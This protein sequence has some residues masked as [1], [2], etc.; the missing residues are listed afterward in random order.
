[1]A[2]PVAERRGRP[3]AVGKLHGAQ[4]VDGFLLVVCARE[5]VE[6]ARR[7]QG[8]R[9]VVQILGRMRFQV[10]ANAVEALLGHIRG[11]V[12]FRGDAGPGSAGRAYRYVRFEW[13]EKQPWLLVQCN[14]AES[15]KWAAF[16]SENFPASGSSLRFSVGGLKFFRLTGSSASAGTAATRTE[17]AA[18]D[19]NRRKRFTGPIS[20][21]DLGVL[22]HGDC[23]KRP[24]PTSPEE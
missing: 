6:I 23:S 16:S 10:G 15:M 5:A 13:H 12:A 14:A 8:H 9:L 7:P 2:F 3:P 4:R 21:E 24:A 1:A 22:F 17:T 11:R 18:T 19:S 20:D